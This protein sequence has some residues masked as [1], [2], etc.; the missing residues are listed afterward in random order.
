M[1]TTATGTLAT[2]FE[3]GDT[4]DGVV[5]ATG[6][7]I[8]IKNQSS[9]AENGIYVVAASGAPTRA[10]DFDTGA[11]ALGAVVKVNEGTAN[12]DSIWQLT[13]NATITIGSTALVFVNLAGG[14]LIW[15]SGQLTANIGSGLDVAGNVIQLNTHSHA[16]DGVQGGR[17]LL[18][19]VLA[20]EVIYES[21][22]TSGAVNAWDPDSN[23]S[24]NG[25]ATIIID[26]ASGP[27]SLNGM[28]AAPSNGPLWV[29]AVNFSGQTITIA[30]ESGSATAARR[31][32]TPSGLSFSWLNL[33]TIWLSY[34]SLTGVGFRWVVAESIPN[35]AHNGPGAGDTLSNAAIASG[36]E[37]AVSK[38]ADGDAL[39]LLRTASNGTDV[40]WGSAGQ[41]VFPATQNASADANTLDDYEHGT[42]TPVVDQ[43]ASTNI[44]KTVTAAHY[45][46]VGASVDINLRLDMT[47]AGTAG[48][49]INI[50][51]PF[52]SVIGAFTFCGLGAAQI[53]D[54]SAGGGL[55][56]FAGTAIQA[57]TAE[58]TALVHGGNGNAFGVSPN[59]AIASGDVITAGIHIVTA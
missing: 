36:A 10:T 5:L 45:T 20:P 32:A 53:Y 34:Q 54:A 29:M 1:A 22:L 31:F 55:N 30:A 18:P 11:K 48:A 24:T 13:T 49:Q 3:N 33:H 40:E 4:V 25:G 8:L 58:F 41:I 28:V 43:G 51:Y 37:I 39:A 7:R 27:I 17:A 46:K 6:N 23:F 56:V 57:S 16:S 9:G 44:A 26:T 14:G 19:G 50:T 47:A 2:A 42:Y 52:T 59:I 35:H 12:A 38:L 15:S 21:G